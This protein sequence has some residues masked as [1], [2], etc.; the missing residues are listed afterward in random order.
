MQEQYC[1]HDWS[2]WNK[3]EATFAL[4]REWHAAW[5]L[6]RV[7]LQPQSG[8]GGNVILQSSS[9]AQVLP[10]HLP[11]SFETYSLKFI[12]FPQNVAKCLEYV[13]GIPFLAKRVATNAAVCIWIPSNNWWWSALV[14]GI[15]TFLTAEHSS[16]LFYSNMHRQRGIFRQPQQNSWRAIEWLYIYNACRFIRETKSGVTGFYR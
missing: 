1:K 6:V 8:S 12:I 7:L 5:H 13:S 11:C 14:A 4:L 16:V 15:A 3:S 9:L 10:R 2:N